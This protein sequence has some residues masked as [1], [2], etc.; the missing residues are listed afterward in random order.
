MGTE[1]ETGPSGVKLLPL[2]IV[3]SGPQ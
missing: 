1:I 3:R 2:E